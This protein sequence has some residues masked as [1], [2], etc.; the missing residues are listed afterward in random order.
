MISISIE[1]PRHKRKAI[2]I[3]ISITFTSIRK[4]VIKIERAVKFAVVVVDRREI[5]KIRD[6]HLEKKTTAMVVVFFLR[7]V[8]IECESL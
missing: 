6:F 4:R 3:L 7:L 8:K 1:R 2:W 5:I